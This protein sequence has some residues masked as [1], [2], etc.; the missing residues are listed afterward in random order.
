MNSSVQ[1]TADITNPYETPATPG[2]C[3]GKSKRRCA[4]VVTAL[5]MLIAVPAFLGLAVD[6][7]L[8]FG[9]LFLYDAEYQAPVAAFFGDLLGLG[10]A[11][12]LMVAAIVLLRGRRR[13]A[14]WTSAAGIALL[15]AAGLLGV[16]LWG[17]PFR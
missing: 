5:L 11:G 9:F 12:L 3:G 8:C 15:G 14:A 4:V 7:A 10:G 13:M 1:P 2:E 6:L 16:L 17:D